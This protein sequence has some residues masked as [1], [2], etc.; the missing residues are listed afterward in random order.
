MSDQR[1]K[2]ALDAGMSLI[3][4]TVSADGTPSCCR[5]VGLASSDDFATV[6]VYLP[7]ATSQRAIQDV[8]TTHRLAV[9]ATHILDNFSI[10][11]KGTTSTARLAREDEAV[12]IER[13]LD[14]FAG[15]LDMIGLPRR[16]THRMNHWPAFAIEMRVEQIFEQTPGPRAGARLQ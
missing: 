1:V 2:R 15:V 4:G 13:W 10:Q 3:V 14:A 16:V 6:T 5:A 9:G 8:A 11:I 12:F 7:L